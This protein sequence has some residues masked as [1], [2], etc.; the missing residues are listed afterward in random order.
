V[1]EEKRRKSCHIFSIQG[2]SFASKLLQHRIHVGR[3]PQCDDVD[4]ESQRTELVF[5]SFS[6]M[7]P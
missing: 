6:I 3:V 7:L 4:D 1:I 2:I 5:L